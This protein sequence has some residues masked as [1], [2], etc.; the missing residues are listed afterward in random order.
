M[1]KQINITEFV[2][3]KIVLNDLGVLTTLTPAPPNTGVYFG[4]VFKPLTLANFGNITVSQSEI[5]ENFVYIYVKDGIF[6]KE[7]TKK[8]IST[9]KIVTWEATS[10]VEG[11]QV[12]KS[13]KI[14]ESTD[15]VLSS[16][17]PGSSNKWLEK[18]NSISEWKAVEFQPKS[19]VVK[20]KVIYQNS[21]IAI[22]TD[23]PSKTS[24]V[25][26]PIGCGNSD[27][28]SQTKPLSSVLQFDKE[29]TVMRGNVTG[30]INF[31]KNESGLKIGN[32][33]LVRL[34]ANGVH[35]P[36]FTG[37]R[38]TNG[39][40]DYLNIS[41]K[42]NCI[43]FFY[44]G[45]DYWYNIWQDA[46]DVTDF[47]QPST[48]SPV[49][50]SN[51]IFNEFSSEFGPAV[52]IQS[53]NL[54]TGSIRQGAYMSDPVIITEGFEL[55]IYDFIDSSVLALDV[56]KD[57]YFYANNQ[58]DS[59]IGLFKYQTMLYAN[60]G[61]GGNTP[62]CSV[63]AITHAKIKRVGNDAKIY[64]SIGGVNYDLALTKPG[65]F[66]GKDSAYIKG[67]FNDTSGSLKAKYRVL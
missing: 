66:S 45:L 61:G 29:I 27:E 34:I 64:T 35:I 24:T 20:D 1:S 55:I 58:D 13:G 36:N 65:V 57:S 60:N 30:A 59:F 5:D 2:T 49:A 11:T 9:S 38:K 41:G 17:I 47:D 51:V 31:V 12:I 43:F 23:V 10:Y 8:P 16:D 18:I 26:T 4:K 33:V 56:V 42:L 52:Y 32:S 44:D 53:D 46:N 6:S 15:N 48:E 14:Y 7:I 21:N 37:F 22:P 54:L 62:I 40:K 63:G 19:L 39:S 3:P 28:V 25:W 67:F 50:I